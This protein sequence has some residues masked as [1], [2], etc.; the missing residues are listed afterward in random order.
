M[1][2]NRCSTQQKLDST[3][4]T[5]PIPFAPVTIS[6]KAWLERIIRLEDSRSSAWCFGNMFFAMNAEVTALG[7][8][9]LMW[10]TF[11]GR[12]LYGFPIGGG[13]LKPAILAL[14]ADAQYRGVPLC[15][16]GLTERSR[17]EMEAAFPGKFDY[18]PDPT[19]YDYIYE[20]EKLAT[21]AGKKLHAKRNHINRFLEEHTD[22]VF[23]PIT[24]ENLSECLAMSREWAKERQELKD[25]ASDLNA[26]QLACDNFEALGLEGGLLR[27]EGRVVAFT[28]GEPLNS[29]TYIV[30]FEKAFSSVQGAYPLVCR[31]FV[32]HVLEVHP[33]IR[34]INRE[35]DL[36][37][38][39]LQRAK[40]SYY[41]VFMVEKYIAHWRDEV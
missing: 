8:R 20:A 28:I 40:R 41:P 27:V 5:I 22:W 6:D 31:E 2:S 18:T 35:E 23:E 7:D 37:I 26:L 17:L 21:L 4:T 13:D 16:R 19:V 25:S 34:Y 38:E 9:L 11:E 10:F 12:S 32:R 14:Q 1:T 29:D 15:I 39:S 24:A 33:H 36:G 30:H 3:H